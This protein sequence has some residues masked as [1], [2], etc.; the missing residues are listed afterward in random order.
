MLVNKKAF[1][2]FFNLA[3][4]HFCKTLLAVSASR[5]LPA[6]TRILDLLLTVLVWWGKSVKFDR[7]CRAFV[8]LNLGSTPGCAVWIGCR[9]KVERIQLG[10][11]H[12]KYGVWKRPYFAFIYHQVF[13][14]CS[15]KV[16]VLQICENVK[17]FIALWSKLITQSSRSLLVWDGIRHFRLT[18]RWGGVKNGGVRSVVG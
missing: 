7:V 6:Q 14:F 13:F 11:A 4:T 8:D 17:D 18:L 16:D 5:G 3:N 9:S 15:S 10:S 1:R 12:E 2:A